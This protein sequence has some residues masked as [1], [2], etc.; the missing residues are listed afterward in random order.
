MRLWQRDLAIE[1]RA[2]ELGELKWAKFEVRAKEKE[3]HEWQQSLEQVERLVKDFSEPGDQVVDPLGG[4]FTTA[5]A[6]KR[7]DRKCISCDNNEAAVIRGQ[8]RLAG[9]TSD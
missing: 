5:V 1:L 7:H 6:C 8:D 4:A 3:W 2:G 9:K